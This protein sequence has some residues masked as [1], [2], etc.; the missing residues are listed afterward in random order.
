MGS[1]V[2][3][4]RRRALGRGALVASIAFGV[5]ATACTGVLEGDHSPE[6]AVSSG[7][8][9]SGSAGSGPLAGSAPGGTTATAPGYMPIHRLNTTEYNTTVADVLGTQL[10]PANG[11]W[12]VYEVNGFDNM[13]DV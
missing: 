7:G 2:G 1:W 5:G 6:G 4:A 12:P 8:G 10:Q 9:S 11:S 3:T 13:A